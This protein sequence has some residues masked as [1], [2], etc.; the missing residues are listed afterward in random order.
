MVKL[1]LLFTITVGLYLLSTLSTVTAT[2]LQR[3]YRQLYGPTQLEH[4]QLEPTQLETTQLGNESPRRHS[5]F[6]GE[7]TR[8]NPLQVGETAQPTQRTRYG[9]NSLDSLKTTDGLG[10]HEQ[11]Q[12]MQGYRQR[13]R[14]DTSLASTYGA[15]TEH[16][17]LPTSLSDK[18]S[19]GH[20]SGTH[21]PERERAHSHGGFTKNPDYGNGGRPDPATYAFY[22]CF[23]T[24][25]YLIQM[26]NHGNENDNIQMGEAFENKRSG[27]KP[28]T[29]ASFIVNID[30]FYDEGYPYGSAVGTYLPY[31]ADD[32]VKVE[33]DDEDC[34]SSFAIFFWDTPPP[35]IWENCKPFSVPPILCPENLGNCYASTYYQPG[36]AYLS[37]QGG[38]KS[39]YTGYVRS[40]KDKYRHQLYRPVRLRATDHC[41]NP[42]YQQ[43]SSYSDSTLPSICPNPELDKRVVYDKDGNPSDDSFPPRARIQNGVPVCTGGQ[44]GNRGGRGGEGGGSG[45]GGSGGGGSGNYG[46]G[47][48]GGHSHGHRPHSSSRLPHGS[49]RHRINKGGL[50]HKPMETTSSDPQVYSLEEMQT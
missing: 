17:Y 32:F 50:P 37:D 39:N 23:P 28:Q 42:T 4:T 31:T 46:G 19:L 10:N 12:G 6:E 41:E 27:D 43:W 30:K 9:P 7:E 14:P 40:R 24:N 35:Q 47:G 1:A 16:G 49:I 18:H 45:S 34:L 13:H 20:G 11:L 5:Q 33:S 44:K 26:G 36:S 38:R 21:K 2:E 15:P 22:G 25:S 29:V 3:R 48:Y 8:R